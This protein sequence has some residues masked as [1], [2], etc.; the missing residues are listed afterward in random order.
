MSKLKDVAKDSTL[1]NV[2]KASI[3]ALAAY[4]EMAIPDI[5][6]VVESS[7]TEEVKVHGLRTIERLKGSTS[8][9]T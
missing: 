1:V 5:T 6:E 2:R 9:E 3:D 8:K 7:N 4:G